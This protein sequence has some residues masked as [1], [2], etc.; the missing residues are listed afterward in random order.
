MR[1][2]GEPIA[3]VL[4]A[5]LGVITL[6]TGHIGSATV[7]EIQASGSAARVIGAFLLIV[8]ATFF[9]SWFKKFRDDQR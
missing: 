7:R 3:G 4:L 9:R 5:A 2:W 6:V 1:N 8:A